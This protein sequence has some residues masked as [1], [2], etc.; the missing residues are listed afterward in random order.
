MNENTASEHNR[1][2]ALLTAQRL[3]RTRPAGYG[4]PDRDEF[5]RDYDRIMFSSGFR[6][7]KDKTQVF[8]L[9]KNDFTRNR[10]THS[11]EV[12][13]V[14]RSLGRSLYRLLDD[15][16]QLP[17][18]RPDIATIVAAACLAH[19]I[20][21]PP[22]GHSGEAAIQAWARTNVGTDTSARF[23]VETTQQARDLHDFEGNA[24][25]IRVL[26]R[27][28]ARR[29]TGGLQ[30]TL[31]TLG[32]MMKYPCT[33]LINGHSRCADRVEQK[34]FGYFEEETELIVPALLKLGLHQYADGAFVRHPLAFLVEAADDICYAIVD[35]ED[36]VD[37]KLVPYEKAFEVLEPIAKL[38][39]ADLGKIYKGASRV[40]WLRAYAIHAL[41]TA[42]K[43]VFE[44]NIEHILN[45]TL[46]RS[47]I[48]L[49]DLSDAY[50]IVK[51]I[52]RDTA[53]KDHRVLEIEAAGFR[54]MGGL[55]DFFVPAVVANEKTRS[56]AESKLFAL[57]PKSYLQKPGHEE[58][59]AEIAVS[60]LTT[61][62]RI[63]AVT[64]YVSGMTDSFAVDL[65]QKLAG[66]KLP[67]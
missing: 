56:R 65:Y 28:Q 49:S 37:Q 39:G 58:D 57:F 67:G 4:D 48:D 16:G 10:L 12:S 31:A 59:D 9:S 52:V 11:L 45:G 50:K 33:S 27:I 54:V 40:R 32:A 14:G 53:Y 17:R 36:S 44:A 19:D 13:C 51:N 18:H 61:Y 64:D 63:L 30:L 21:N 25:G 2:D 1:W 7:L 66:I 41:I 46:H 62:Q 38:A 29:R 26:S 3:G 42:C 15:S 23:V 5:D 55:L 20:G 24:Q 60:K 34:K 8:P 22:F 43:S 6:R 47:L 35:L